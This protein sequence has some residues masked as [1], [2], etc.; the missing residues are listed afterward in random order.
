M[1]AWAKGYVHE[2]TRREEINFLLR[3]NQSWVI[4]I[5]G[6]CVLMAYYLLAWVM[7]GRDPEAFVVITRYE[8]PVGLSPGSSRYI[9][10]MGYDHMSFAASLVNLAVKGLIEIKE[11]GRKYTLN[12]TSAPLGELAAGE[13]EILKNLFHNLKGTSITLKQSKHSTIRKTLKAHEAALGRNSEKLYFVRNRGWLIPV[14]I[15]SVLI[16]AGVIYG[17]PSMDMKITGLFL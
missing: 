6:L 1:V 11:E 15:F 7:V 13:K 14:I 3:D 10:R 2:P 16:Y 9:D 4:M 17:L 12:R 5:I 8:T